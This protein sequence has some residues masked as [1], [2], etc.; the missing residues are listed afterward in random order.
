[1]MM[2]P[3]SASAP[4]V[5]PASAP[6]ARWPHA[7]VLTSSLAL[8]G[9]CIA[10]SLEDFVYGIPARFHLSVMTAALL[11]GAAFVVQVGG[12]VLATSRRRL[13]YLVTGLTGAGW[14]VAAAA[15][16]LGEVVFV[17]PYREG[18]LSKALEVGIMGIGAL[19][20][21]VSLWALLGGASRHAR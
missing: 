2:S 19:L 15:D 4:T 8:I 16:H 10:H 12:I 6:T 1:M 20:A 5:P 13:G 11:L 9:V 7:L 14:A 3:Q 18:I 21:I 17:S